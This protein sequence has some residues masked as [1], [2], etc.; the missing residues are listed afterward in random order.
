MTTTIDR[1]SFNT[2]CAAGA[3]VMAASTLA[4]CSSPSAPLR[5]YRLPGEP[6]AGEDAVPRAASGSGAVWELA[7]AL[8]MPELLERDTLFVEDGA[9]VIRLLHGHRWAEPL[10]DTLPRLLRDDLARLVPGLWTASTA[11]APSAA[12]AGRVQV[13][14]LA[15]QGSLP[16]RQ[17]AVSARWVV[18]RAAPA[19]PQALRIDET[20]PW[21]D[22]T[23]ESLVVAQRV[24]MWRLAQRIAASLQGG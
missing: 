18:T 8:P 15:L 10:R 4:A 12:V 24:A 11:T 22:A 1:R 19:Q 13:E 14:L 6:P 5:W 16:R 9:A 17:V 20:V 23:P 21:T 2:S 7:P 3:F